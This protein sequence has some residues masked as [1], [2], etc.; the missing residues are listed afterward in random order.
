L[1]MLHVDWCGVCRHTLPKFRA[2]AEDALKHGVQMAEIDV[3][4]DKTLTKRYEIKGFPGLRFFEGKETLEPRDYRNGRSEKDFVAFAQ[5][6]ARPPITH[7]EVPFDV[8]RILVEEPLATF[9]LWHPQK[10][11]PI[12]EAFETAAKEFRDKHSA[13]WVE[14]K[15]LLPE[16][17][18]S[19]I[20]EGATSAIMVVAPGNTQY[21]K[22]K[23]PVVAVYSG[24][25][26]NATRVTKWASDN[27]YPGLWN[28]TDARFH[29]FSSSTRASAILVV[30]PKSPEK[31]WKGPTKKAMKNMSKFF[32]FG[33]LNGTDWKDALAD[34]QIYPEEYPRLLVL[35]PKFD[36][37]YAEKDTVTVGD[38]TNS[39]QRIVDGQIHMQTRSFSNKLY[40][41]YR[42]ARDFTFITVDFMQES[43]LNAI[44]V[45]TSLGVL[46]FTIFKCCG[47]CYD[48]MMMDD[49]YYDQDYAQ[50]PAAAKK[51]D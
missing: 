16:A 15:G 33:V 38:M 28:I 4:N 17:V 19:N 32:Q 50:P 45:A 24:D 13:V 42:Y 21:S 12:Y 6:M 36:G 9:I 35:A 7:A 40:V 49:T 37:Y 39:L 30:D 51:K 14:D 10:K 29:D 27:R 31:P 8:A 18:A 44:L 43:V 2:A 20:P 47:F 3:T 46:L 26:E 25:M 11:G 41:G 48:I 23:D 34:F 5:R 22:S 1:V